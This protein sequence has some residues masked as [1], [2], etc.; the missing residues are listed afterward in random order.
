MDKLM[1]YYFFYFIYRFVCTLYIV[2]YVHMYSLVIECNCAPND[3]VH[4]QQLHQIDYYYYLC[5]QPGNT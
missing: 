4:M 1:N 3:D 5:N 2:L